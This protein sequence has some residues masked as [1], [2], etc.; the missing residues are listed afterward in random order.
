MFSVALI[1]LVSLGVVAFAA[2]TVQI[3]V[4]A[5]GPLQGIKKALWKRQ[6]GD[7]FPK[8]DQ[9][10]RDLLSYLERVI[11]R[12]INKARGIL[13]FNSVI[14]AV[15]SIERS[16]IPFSLHDPEG[17]HTYL[18]A[19]LFLVMFGL[20]ASSALC[21]VL[22]VVHWG[23]ASQYGE[24]NTEVEGTV[25]LI[26]IRSVLLQYA[27]VLSAASLLFGAIV[28][29]TSEWNFQPALSSCAPRQAPATAPSKP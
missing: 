13:P 17:W 26:R 10:A 11:D 3:L 8:E 4:P 1:V 14:L 27:I 22:F 29:L 2:F 20:A 24:F 12:Q 16:R 23:P 19:F 21:L 25:S 28:V 6:T 9:K 5:S 7:D 18:L 15:L